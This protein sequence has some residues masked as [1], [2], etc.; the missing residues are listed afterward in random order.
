MLKISE[1]EYVTIKAAIKSN[2]N[3]R[4][5]KDLKYWNFAMP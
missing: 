5:A 2:K 1:A 4:V 3:K